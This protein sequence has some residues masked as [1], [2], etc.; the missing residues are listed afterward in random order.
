[1]A[2]RAPYPS[3]ND[4]YHSNLSN[5]NIQPVANRTMVHNPNLHG[6][7]GNKQNVSQHFNYMTSPPQSV[8]P[9]NL[10]SPNTV[11]RVGVTPNIGDKNRINEIPF[12]GPSTVNHS[13]N[14]F[15]NFPPQ[16]KNTCVP[17]NQYQPQIERFP[18]IPVNNN[19]RNSYPNSDQRNLPNRSFF[20]T[21]QNTAYN[22]APPMINY[23]RHQNNPNVNVA[24]SSMVQ[25]LLPSSDHTNVN[26]NIN[27]FTALPTNYSNVRPV[28]IDHSKPQNLNY[29][30][31][32]PAPPVFGNHTPVSTTM[33]HN[34]A[35]PIPL[36]IVQNNATGPHTLSRTECPLMC[37]KERN[38]NVFLKNFC[39]VKKQTNNQVTV[40]YDIALVILNL[41]IYLAL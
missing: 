34:V 14:R 30:N 11:M 3:M 19:S 35:T 37:E 2:Y 16:S 18:N 25:P 22:N 21:V 6:F 31:P 38:L 5:K 7:P 23:Q 10:H 39:D 15:M 9:S 40:S 33:F 20:P 24:G 1:M 4:S 41:N 28:N 12:T 17:Y 36:Q 26:Q 8:N 27:N 29:L 13:P 32:V